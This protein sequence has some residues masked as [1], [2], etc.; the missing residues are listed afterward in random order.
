MA[1]SK[2]FAAR[3][4]GKQFEVNAPVDGVLKVETGGEGVVG[5]VHL[6]LLEPNALDGVNSIV[7]SPWPSR[8]LEGLVFDGSV[9]LKPFVEHRF[10]NNTLVVTLNDKT[11][12]ANKTGTI[13][14]IDFFR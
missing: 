4:G 12:F 5:I 14:L 8:A 2:A 13:S 1:S 7:V 10:D 3:S 9:D 6:D 11:I